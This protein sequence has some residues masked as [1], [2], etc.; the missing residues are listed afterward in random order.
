MDYISY[1]TKYANKQG[2]DKQ[3]I[4]VDASSKTLGRLASQIAYMIRGKHKPSFTPHVDCGDHVI[5][6]N[7]DKI[8]LSGNKWV[9]K[10]YVT[11]S[12][13]PGGVKK[14]TPRELKA[15]HPKRII[16]HAVKGML[17]KNRLGRRLF[18]NLHVCEG[19]VHQYAAQKPSQVML[20]Y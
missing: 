14:T 17:P 4:V 9:K 11:Y 8:S 16:E 20:K 18:H 19:H 10:E 7:A 2:V 1:K 3:W 5:V 15:A 12:G 13:Y 6:L